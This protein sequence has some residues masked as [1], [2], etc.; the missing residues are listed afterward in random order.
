MNIQT[1]RKKI[2]ELQCTID[3]D[4][5]VLVETWLYNEIALYNIARYT[6]TYS[7]RDSKGGDWKSIFKNP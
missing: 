7:C 4:I 5:L 3:C 2:D 6:A 1:V